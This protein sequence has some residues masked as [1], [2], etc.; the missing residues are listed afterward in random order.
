[1]GP[2]SAKSLNSHSYFN[3]I[4]VSK[5]KREGSLIVIGGHR[6]AVARNELSRSRDRGFA[7]M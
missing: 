7:L 1:M 6:R 3:I 4:N 5:L 2:M